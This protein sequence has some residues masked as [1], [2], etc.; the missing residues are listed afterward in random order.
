MIFSLVSRIT[1]AQ[2]CRTL[3]AV[4]DYAPSQ[5]I[6]HSNSDGAAQTVANFDRAF[7]FVNPQAGRGKA[8]KLISRLGPT[9]HT[10]GVTPEIRTV[11]SSNEMGTQAKEAIQSGAKLLFAL[12]GDGTLQVLANAVYGQD[13][14]LGV[15]P[16][17]G[18]NDFARALG[19]PSEPLA[20]LGAALHGGPRFADLVRVRTADGHQRLYLG[21][22][23]IGLDA[24]AAKFA[25]GRYRDW[26]GRSRYLAAAIHAYATHKPRRVRVAFEYSNEVPKWHESVLACVLN[27]P[28]FG[29]GI[30]L[31]P[32]AR[33]NDGL[34]DFVFLDELR[35]STLLRILPQLALRGTLDIPQLQ[36]KQFRKLR[37]ET[38]QPAYFHGDGE[39]LGPTPVEIEVVP[40]AAQFLAPKLALG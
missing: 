10:H 32:N 27:T 39:I 23:G 28:T 7:V 17:G 1:T 36:A 8:R 18:G 20:A 16:A 11:S 9:F 33:I 2:P 3:R 25:G 12:G 34:L 26:P 29:A 35:V 40:G 4:T 6:L 14:V 22:G 38:E 37:L 24:D 30:R 21:G 5:M 13:A 31:A 19:L 15:I